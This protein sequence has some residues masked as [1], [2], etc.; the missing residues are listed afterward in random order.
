MRVEQAV[1]VPGFARH[2]TFHL[3]YGW[4]KK[5]H[6]AVSHDARIF[7]R[8]DALVR[9]GV[10][11]NMV[12][13][14]RFW[15]LATKVIRQVV[16]PGE[17]S[18]RGG[19][20]VAVTEMGSAIFD[21]QKGRD[22]YLERPETLWLLHWNLYSPPSAIPAWWILVNDLGAA[23]VS[24]DELPRHVLGRVSMVPD[25][26]IPN[27]SSIKKDTDAFVHTYSSRR[28]RAGDVEDYMDCP[29]RALRLLRD[30]AASGRGIQFAVG[31]KPGMSAGIVEH[32]CLDWIARRGTGARTAS[33]G[34]LASEPGG[35]GQVLKLD[36]ASLAAIL[37]EAA[38]ERGS[39]IGVQEI[40][41]VAH[42]SFPA[43]A[44]GAAGRALGRAY[45]RRALAAAP[46]ARAVRR[47][48]K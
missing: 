15:G 40:N 27:E 36:E 22:P 11:K 29:F 28:G 13:A 35:P 41:G 48:R 38:S 21:D 37:S 30:G 20:E 32:I 23:H 2:E 8:E 12:R 43:D 17:G 42:L 34:S 1:P 5:C 6:D 18:R 9:L 45:A 47:G 10:G 33:V 24:A 7:Q 46:R 16:A 31:P 44:A 3:R 4:L 25:W 14:I 26:A 19:Q 39:A